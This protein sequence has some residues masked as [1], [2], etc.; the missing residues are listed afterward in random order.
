MLGQGVFRD[1]QSLHEAYGCDLDKLVEGDKV[2]VM[3]NSRVSLLSFYFK[4]FLLG[5]KYVTLLIQVSI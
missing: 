3:R 1:G 2:G 4:V 5:S